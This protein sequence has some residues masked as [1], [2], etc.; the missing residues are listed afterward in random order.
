MSKK[1]GVRHAQR[2]ITKPMRD[3]LHV[4]HVRMTRATLQG[5][6]LQVSRTAQVRTVFNLIT[7]HTQ[8]LCRIVFN[9]PPTAKV[10]ST[11]LAQLSLI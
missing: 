10:I 5:R 1:I 9:V 6:D 8:L 7:A 3:S 2:A 11:W 4:W